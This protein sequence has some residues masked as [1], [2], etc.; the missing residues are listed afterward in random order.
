MIKTRSK[1]A[2]VFCLL[3][4]AFALIGCSLGQKITLEKQQTPNTNQGVS[5][6]ANL[7]IDFGNGETQNFTL[8]F[9]NE[10]TVYDFL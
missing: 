2:V 9:R 1:F 10:R 5:Q 4:L 3:Y 7:S 6:K 8:E